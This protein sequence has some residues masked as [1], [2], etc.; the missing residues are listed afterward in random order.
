MLQGHSQFIQRKM[1]KIFINI[2]NII[3]SRFISS[4]FK[5]KNRIFCHFPV[6][7]TGNR[8]ISF[9]KNCFVGKNCIFSAW[10]QLRKQTFSP[11]IIIGNHCDFGEYNHISAIN[12]IQI[13]DGLLTGRWVTITDNAHGNPDI[14]E[15]NLPPME[16][17]VYSKGPIVIGSNVWIGD[18]ATILPGVTIGDGAVIGA[19]T[20]VTHN[21]PPYSTAVGNPMRI[22]KR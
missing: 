22:I 3:Y 1:I 16:R 14:N 20:V 10:E 13:G 12:K 19:N 15:N 6:N 21:V 7:I 9:G 18:K 17:T 8:N 4:T 2:V 11:T 5:T